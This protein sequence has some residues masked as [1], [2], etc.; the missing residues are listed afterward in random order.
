[1]VTL[2]HLAGLSRAEIGEQMGKTE[3]AVRALLH[4]AKA[5]LAILLEDAVG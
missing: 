3:E 5:R 1:V 4:R 2:A